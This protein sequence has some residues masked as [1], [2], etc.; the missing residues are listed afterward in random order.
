VTPTGEVLESLSVV[1]TGVDVLEVNADFGTLY[2]SLPFASVPWSTVDPDGSLW[3]GVTGAYRMVKLRP[4]GDTALVIERNRDPVPVTDEELQATLASD[5]GIAR[6]S[7]L[8]VTV[9]P[10]LI[11]LN[12]PALTHVEVSERGEIWVWLSA[13]GSE[14]GPIDV[15]R[16]DGEYVGSVVSPSDFDLRGG[17]PVILE[18]YVV[19]VVADSLGVQSVV[20]YR[21]ER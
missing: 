3:T 13:L 6:L 14:P 16:A 4:S 5:P 18:D 7:E 17:R 15:F 9:D 1:K 8:G 12:K 20:R 11:S 10:S 21:I 2:T 19:G